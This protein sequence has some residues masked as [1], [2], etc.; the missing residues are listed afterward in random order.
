VITF[1]E[2][3]DGGP[4]HLLSLLTTYGVELRKNGELIIS[5]IITEVDDMD[6]IVGVSPWI[7][8]DDG[9]EHLSNEVKFFGVYEDFDEVVYM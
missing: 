6:D 3:A 7:I 4:S 8:G 1:A 2:G 9:L 5:G